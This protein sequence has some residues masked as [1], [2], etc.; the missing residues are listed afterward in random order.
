MNGLPLSLRDFLAYTTSGAV[1]MVAIL[2]AARGGVDVDRDY[3]GHVVTAFVVGSYVVGHLL[4]TSSAYLVR[5][6]RLHRRTNTS[7][8]AL[9]AGERPRWA[10][11]YPLPASIRARVTSAAERF[12]IDVD[13]GAESARAVS[14]VAEAVV[15]EVHGRS[16]RIDRWGTLYDF[17]RNVAAALAMGAVALAV[18]AVAHDDAEVGMAAAAALV[19]AVP[20]V[21]RYLHFYTFYQRSLLTA[22][23]ELVHAGETAASTEHAAV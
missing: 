8:R 14:L 19:L 18:G 22:F 12:G 21:F 10:A 13:G 2:V 1:L 17:N 6:A 23:A 7:L 16:T 20:F 4:G 5:K 3:G 9:V 11:G 15:R